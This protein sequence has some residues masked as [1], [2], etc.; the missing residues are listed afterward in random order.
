MAMVGPSMTVQGGRDSVGSCHC[1]TLSLYN[2]IKDFEI[3]FQGAGRR[4]RGDTESQDL[5]LN[6]C[7]F[8]QVKQREVAT[9][10]MLFAARG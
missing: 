9:L 7:Y 8:M 4:G 5:L 10:L 6:Q 1:N 2:Y 3:S